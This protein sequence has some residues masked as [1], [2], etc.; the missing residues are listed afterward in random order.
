[1]VSMFEASVV[2]RAF[3]HRSGETKDRKGFCC[4]FAKH[5]ALRGRTNGIKIMFLFGVTCLSVD[6]CFS[7][8]TL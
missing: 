1:M 7:K 6:H 2:D 3:G 4:F 5:A 8:L